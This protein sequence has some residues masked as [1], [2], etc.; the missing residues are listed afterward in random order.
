MPHST[1]EIDIIANAKWA[2]T[3]R[4]V[5]RRDCVGLKADFASAAPGDLVLC[6]VL[7][8]G[9]HKRVQLT[10]G[11]YST[12]YPGDII[13][14]ACGGRYAP[15]QYEGIAEI[16]EDASD[17][18]AGGGVVGTMRKSNNRMSGPTKVKPLGIISHADGRAV[19]IAQYALADMVLP[20]NLTIIAAVGSSMNGG[21][22]TAVASFAHGLAKAGHK[23]AAIK[24][25]GTGSF[26]DFNTYA[27]TSAHF[28]ADFVDVGMPSTYQIPVDQI[29]SGMNSLLGHASAAGCTVA[30]VEFADGIFQT[31]TATLLKTPEVRKILDG[32]IFAAPCA[33]S[34]VGGCEALR[35]MGIEPSIVTGKV[36]ASPLA[37]EEAEKIAAVSIVTKEELIGPETADGLLEFIRGSNWQNVLSA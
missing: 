14:L 33:A 32:V 5:E 25:T 17:M 34:V 10:V 22:T 24:V 19:N 16:D 27:D 4:R 28:V 1:S 26:G 20:L 36:S 12:L 6:E 11:R 31:E 8:I 2:F 23:V 9:S 15:D 30:V 3:T 7:S 37:I 35:S 13:V 21:K 29:I 18:L